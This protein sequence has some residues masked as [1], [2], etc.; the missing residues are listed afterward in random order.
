M[1]PSGRETRGTAVY[2]TASLVRNFQ[3][4]S[5]PLTLQIIT[6][7]P[8]GIFNCYRLFSL[9][10]VTLRNSICNLEGRDFFSLFFS[11]FESLHLN[12][13]YFLKN[14]YQ[15]SIYYMLGSMLGIPGLVRE[16]SNIGWHMVST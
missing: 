13:H 8:R 14:K 10:C 16:I 9:S 5:L 12:Y 11:I 7:L 1:S 15:L 2:N 3:H 6:I 4:S